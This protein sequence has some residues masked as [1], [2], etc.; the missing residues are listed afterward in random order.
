MVSQSFIGVLKKK[1]KKKSFLIMVRKYT[2][3]EYRRIFRTDETLKMLITEE[4]F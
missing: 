2:V 3:T 4:F 1:R